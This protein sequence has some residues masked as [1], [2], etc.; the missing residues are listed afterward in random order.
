MDIR[1]LILRALLI[2]LF[3]F[4]AWYF[5]TFDEM[6]VPPDHQKPPTKY[7]IYEPHH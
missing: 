3:A 1:A 6:P 4:G 5:G 2:G 7:R